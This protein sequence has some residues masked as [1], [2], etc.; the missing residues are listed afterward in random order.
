MAFDV[1]AARQTATRLAE[2]ASNLDFAVQAVM[3]IDPSIDSGSWLNSLAD[4]GVRPTLAAQVF[5]S[6]ILN[7]QFPD[8]HWGT[9]DVRPPQSYSIVTSTAVAARAIQRYLPASMHAEQRAAVDRAREW[10][11][12]VVPADNEERTFQLLGLSWAR[13]R[14]GRARPAG[15]RAAGHAAAD[16][17]WAQLPRLGSDAYATGQALVALQRAGGLPA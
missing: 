15:T 4:I 16:G 14:T 2:P 13:G 5:A 7:R 1:E 17:G 6:R 3:Q 8:G 12:T 9:I 11:R 10:L